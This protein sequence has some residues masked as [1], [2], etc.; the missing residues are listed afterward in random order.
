MPITLWLSARTMEFA[1]A[2]IERR[3]RSESTML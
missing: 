1:R 2:G 3:Q